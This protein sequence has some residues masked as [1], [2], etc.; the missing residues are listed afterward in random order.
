VDVTVVVPMHN[1]EAKVLECLTSIHSQTKRPAKVIVVDDFSTDRSV[2]VVRTAA[3]PDV[4][5]V[6]LKANKGP[7]AARNIG[8]S[9]AQTDWIAFL[10]ADD[11]WD[12][13]FLERVTGAIRRFG[14]DFGSSGGTRELG[15]RGDSTS[16]V[17]VMNGP[18]DPVDLTDSFW[19]AAM[20][21]MPIH[22]SAA[23]VRRELFER[24][25]GYCETAWSGEDVPLWA[26][27]W[28][29]GRFA[30]VNEALFTSIA[31]PSGLSARLLAY[32]DVWNPL[33]L[34]A[35]S[36]WRSIRAHRRGTA[37]FALWFVS[38]VI[39]RHGTYVVRRLRRR[40]RSIQNGSAP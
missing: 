33:A 26:E 27:L 21:F 22:P 3:I 32:A 39:R 30:F 35:R 6:T 9:R 31:T 11:V 14:A 13:W 23:V 36:L 2:E 8:A 12:P 16:F 18:P 17:R 25:G 24:S 20:R 29:N 40:K 37:W 5:V 38:A 28:R 1:M 19:R 15:Y 10:D 34:I 4:E 7:G